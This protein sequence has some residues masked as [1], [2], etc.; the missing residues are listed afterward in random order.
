MHPEELWGPPDPGD[1]EPE[2]EWHFLDAGDDAPLPLASRISRWSRESAAGAM[3]AGYA[4][5]LHDLLEGR[6]R[7]QIVIEVDADGEPHDLP[8]E[9]FLDPDSPEGSL[10]IVHRDR[11]TPPQL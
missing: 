6:E 1:D 11:L 3:L 9:L 4:W 10:C 7:N 2:W 5:A 8:I